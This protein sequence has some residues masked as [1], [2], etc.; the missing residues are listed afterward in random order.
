MRKHL[1]LIIRLALFV[2]LAAVAAMCVFWMPT[3]VEYAA[4]FFGGDGARPALYAVCGCIAAILVTVLGMAFRLPWAI[5]ADCIF[6]AK[7]ALLLRRIAWLIFGD[8]LFF[9][10]ASVALLAAGDRLLAPA[11]LFVDG[12]GFALML[13]LWVL[14]D[15][16]NRAAVLKEEADATL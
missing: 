2:L 8:C 16:V 3:A 1:S 14:A 5:S 7:T 4:S 13:M 15:Y 12:I 9:G 10:A 6:H 11:L